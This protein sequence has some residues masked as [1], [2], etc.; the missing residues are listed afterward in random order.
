MAT[1]K[2]GRDAGNGKF[3][4]VKQAQ[5]LGNKAVV[6]NQDEGLRL[7]TKALQ[8]GLW[9]QESSQP[10]LSSNTPWYGRCMAAGNFYDAKTVARS[11]RLSC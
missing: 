1:R 5:K 7:E 2:I 9:G 3:I 8:L 11:V 6:E 4:P 10:I